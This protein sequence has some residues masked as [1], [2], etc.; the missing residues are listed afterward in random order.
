TLVIGSG[1]DLVHPLA[2]ARSLADTIPNAAFVEVTPKATDKE[3]HFAEI[4]AAIGGFLNTNFDK[5]DQS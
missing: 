3:R 4:R 2:T 1:I 5:Q